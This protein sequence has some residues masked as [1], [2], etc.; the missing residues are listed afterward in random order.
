MSR[1]AVRVDMRFGRLD[2]P[3]AESTVPRNKGKAWAGKKRK[4]QHRKLSVYANL[5]LFRQ[6]RG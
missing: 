5:K 6:P 4:R 2:N 1:E 3:L